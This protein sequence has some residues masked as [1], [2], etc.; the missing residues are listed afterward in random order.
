MPFRVQRLR[1]CRRCCAKRGQMF[2]CQPALC[3]EGYRL[4]Q[5]KSDWLNSFERDGFVVIPDVINDDVVDR[6]IDS[7]PAGNKILID[8]QHSERTYAIRN[9]FQGF[10]EVRRLA[11][12]AAIRALAEPM[13]GPVAFA[14]RGLF[15]DKTP[16]A[17]WKV[18]WHQD[19]SIAVRHRI[20]VPGFGPWSVKAGVVH[21]QPPTEILERM[22]VVRVHLDDCSEQNG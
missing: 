12:S 7:L 4:K 15:F 18:S 5:R 8:L 13:L 1:C 16:E 17:N 3:R 19:L 2:R 9:L 11:E 22:I 20:E 10:P 6:L 14:V 21:V